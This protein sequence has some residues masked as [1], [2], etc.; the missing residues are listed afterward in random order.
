MAENLDN[1]LK[2]ESTAT[3]IPAVQEEPFKFSKFRIKN[4]CRALC[5]PAK[6]YEPQKTIDSIKGY[7][8]EKSTKERILYSEISTFVFGL[9]P[10]AQGVFATNIERLVAYALDE[11]N[12]VDDLHCKIIIKIYDHF[13]LACNQKELTTS[14][15]TSGFVSHRAIPRLYCPLCLSSMMNGSMP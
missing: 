3:D 2:T 8:A 14:L 13:Q 7:L 10:D 12:H 11:A 1:L 9:Q 5:L 15:R 4:I 6:T